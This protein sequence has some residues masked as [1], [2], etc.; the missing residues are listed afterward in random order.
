MQRR[1]MPV[2]YG[3]FTRRFNIDGFKGQGY[4]DEFFFHGVPAS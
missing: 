2:P 3:F 4:F 1:G